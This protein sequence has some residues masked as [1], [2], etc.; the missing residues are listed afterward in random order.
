MHEVGNEIE[1]A[2]FIGGQY[3]ISSGRTSPGWPM[4]MNDIRFYNQEKAAI[5]SRNTGY[6]ISNMHVRNT[7]VGIEL[8]DGI[9]DRL[10]MENCCFEEVSDCGIRI[11]GDEEPAIR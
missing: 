4:I 5:V 3:G 6:A 2:D 11:T 1:D 7:A 8:E 9:P 10:Y